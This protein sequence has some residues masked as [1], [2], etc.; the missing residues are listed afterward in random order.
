VASF[1]EFL[2]AADKLRPH[3]AIVLGSGQAQVLS[4]LRPAA[5]IGFAEAPGLS[6]PTVSGHAGTI[7]VGDLRGVPVLVFR[8]RLH[9][10]ECGS[11]D[12]V[13][14]PIRFA[15]SLGVKSLL[16]TNAAGGIH[17][18]LRPG[19]LMLIRDHLSW[20]R[21][22]AW[23]GPGPA[24]CAC[25]AGERSSLYSARLME[26]LLAAAQA[27]GE[28]LRSGVYAAVTGP[29][30]E[31]PAEIRALQAAGADAVGMSTVH[32]V[33]TGCALGLECAGISGI[34]NKAAGLGG[35]TLNHLEVLQVMAGMQDKLG[36]LIGE[37]VRR[38]EV[39]RPAS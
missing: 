31:T 13:A 36:R 11:W 39:H 2:R 29:C 21:P 34:T 26:L 23:R 37:F 4:D 5:A 19:S 24:G 15:A 14:S 9:F 10:Y 20:Q 18:A 22:G 12:K 6:A 8:G 17:P 38:A 32:E 27:I 25:L 28:E 33:D 3:A 1:D 7:V 35:G 16:L 30:Y